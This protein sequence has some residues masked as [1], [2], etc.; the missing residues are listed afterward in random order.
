MDVIF[1]ASLGAPDFPSVKNSTPK[2]LRNMGGGSSRPSPPPRVPK[3]LPSTTIWIQHLPP[4]IS[5]T[6]RQALLFI[7]QIRSQYLTGGI[8]NVAS[9]DLTSLIERLEL[10]IED[11]RHV[12]NIR[13]YITLCTEETMLRLLNDHGP[14]SQK[15]LEIA[16]AVNPFLGSQKT[17]AE[18]LGAASTSGEDDNLPIPF[19]PSDTCLIDESEKDLLVLLY[20]CNVELFEASI[21]EA[22]GQL[23]KMAKKYGTVKDLDLRK[24]SLS[25]T[26][27]NIHWILFY[28][29]NKIS[30]AIAAGGN[31]PES[32]AKLDFERSTRMSRLLTICEMLLSEGRLD[33]VCF[34]L[35][36]LRRCIASQDKPW[37]R[38]R[39]RR[40]LKGIKKTRAGR[41][42][43]HIQLADEQLLCFKG[44]EN[45]GGKSWGWRGSSTIR[46]ETIEMGK[47]KGD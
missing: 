46:P 37:W 24:E 22:L 31:P 8:S 5:E 39:T 35:I 14:I 10:L 2:L 32:G 7:R 27:I 34:L 25:E 21:E 12:A 42:K 13:D 15:L 33:Q 29:E 40:L 43:W 30:L 1:Y 16:H 9:E 45:D 17:D 4:L 23:L 47:V 36:P 20:Y 11:A 44:L 3:T 26:E 6:T 18:R 19:R 41:Q 28:L 38:S